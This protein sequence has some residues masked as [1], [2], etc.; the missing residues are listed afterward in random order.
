MTTDPAPPTPPTP[1]TTPTQQNT[2][3]VMTRLVR[4]A[5][6]ELGVRVDVLGEGWILRL[7]EEGKEKPI[8][9][10]RHV[11]GYSFD[12]NPAATHQ[13]CCDKAATSEVLASSGVPVVPHRL[14]L[15]PSMA[16]FVPHKGTWEGLL[17]AFRA[18]GQDVV[19]KDNEGTG[20]R[21]VT[22]CRSVVELEEAVYRQF[23]RTESLCVSPFVE[24]VHEYRFVML[25]DGCECVYEKV[26]AC[27]TGDGESTLLELLARQPLLRGLPMAAL[28]EN[29]EERERSALT[30]VV[31]RGEVRMPNWRH[32]LGQGASARLVGDADAKALP[33]WGI[34]HDAARVLGLRFGSVDVVQVQYPL[35]GSS[36]GVPGAAHRWHDGWGILEVN[37]GVMMEF[38]ARTVPGGEAIARRVYGRAVAAMFA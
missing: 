15:H 2:E 27:V 28:L 13:I 18:W 31:P 11:H 1:P 23:E 24:I 16:K 3:R 36:A 4:E 25:G 32:N 7:V 29:L 21:G 22:R 5:A 26:R 9:R 38:L 37:S 10:V 6:R 19:V 20:G 35:S 33:A 30:R 14:F 12:L 8:P 34:A 17:A